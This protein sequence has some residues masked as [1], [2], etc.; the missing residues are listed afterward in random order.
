MGATS[1]RPNRERAVIDVEGGKITERDLKAA[2]KV[3]EETLSDADQI[4]LSNLITD[5]AR[6]KNQSPTRAA[7]DRD[8]ATPRDRSHVESERLRR[9]PLPE[10]AYRAPI[11]ARQRKVRSALKNRVMAAAPQSQHRAVETLLASP[12]PTAW[13]RVN[14]GLHRAAGNVHALTDKDRAM[15]QRLDRAIGSYEQLNDRDHTVYVGVRLPDNTPSVFDKRDLPAGLKVGSR[16]AFDQFTPA[17]HNLHELPGHDDQRV[18]V[19]EI[20]TS[21]GMYMGLSTSGDDTSHLLPRGM[22]LRLTRAA[23]VPYFTGS[24]LGERLVVQA[25]DVFTADKPRPA[26]T[27][28]L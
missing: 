10:I 14:D 20:T 25:Q 17:T 5:L 15:V 27:G 18:V 19:L 23:V 1:T 4:R 21:R 6:D 22:H 24:G 8:R 7:R 3:A 28:D 26:R 11:S 9:E 13:R 16:I 2:R 12:D